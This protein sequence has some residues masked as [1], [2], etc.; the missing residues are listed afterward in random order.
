LIL[1]GV[2][3]YVGESMSVY[4]RIGAHVKDTKKRF[5][6]VRILPCL[7]HRRKYWEAI[8]IDRY[9][10]IFNTKGKDK[11]ANKRHIFELSKIR[12]NQLK[13][14][15]ECHN[16]KRKKANSIYQGGQVGYGNEIVNFMQGGNTGLGV[17]NAFSSAPTTTAVTSAGQVTLETVPASNDVYAKLAHEE[18]RYKKE[19]AW[20]D[21]VG[22]VEKLNNS[23]DASFKLSNPYSNRF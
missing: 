3:V 18:E 16:C 1:E 10:P 21:S 17:S 12:K 6:T 22:Y 19:V 15:T 11:A 23:L 5:D 2:V 8:L 7:E 14:T 20:D 13:T 9:Q 4:S